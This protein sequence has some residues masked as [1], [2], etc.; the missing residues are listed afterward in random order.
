M[1]LEG[2]ECTC[3]AVF[4]SMFVMKWRFYQWPTEEFR[5]FLSVWKNAALY[6][7]KQYGSVDEPVKYFFTHLCTD[8]CMFCFCSDTIVVKASLSLNESS[9]LVFVFAWIFKNWHNSL[10]PCAHF[11]N[12]S[13]SHGNMSNKRHSCFSY[14]NNRHIIHIY[15]YTNILYSFVYKLWSWMYVIM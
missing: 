4:L 1:Y 10:S 11:I 8:M 13:C 2:N 14:L 15:V 12:T 6:G 3:L 9:F 5:Y 7:R